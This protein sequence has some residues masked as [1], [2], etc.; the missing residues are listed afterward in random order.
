MIIYK[1]TNK[2]NNKQYV[3]L[4]EKSIIERFEQ[5]IKLS[6]NGKY[7]L[8]N[9]IKK[10]GKDNFI[11]EEIEKC[12]SIDELK[13]REIYWIKKLNSKTPNGYNMTD[14]GDGLL[15]PSSEIRE[16]MSKAKKGKKLSD[17][18][19]FK[20]HLASLNQSEETRKKN[21]LANSG[22]NH[23]MFGKH[24]S[25]ITKLKMSISHQNMS[26]ETREKIRTYHLGKKLQL[27]Q[28]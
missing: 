14:G 23:R 17:S 12:N 13:Q 24:H 19:K 20:L 11:I 18:H 27:K 2:I 5:H 15:N 21:S 16:K 6:K 28:N 8:H 22:K 9:A 7:Y 10:Y 1:I 4:T 3:G 25:E 26:N